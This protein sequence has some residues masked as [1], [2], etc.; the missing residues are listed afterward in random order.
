MGNQNQSIYNIF[1]FVTEEI[2][3]QET[4]DVLNNILTEYKQLPY[5]SYLIR[6]TSSK[7]QEHAPFKNILN[8]DYI[9]R[10]FS[11]VEDI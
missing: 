11:Y 8:N 3:I 7:P 10:C 6:N 9:I 2:P 1:F 4:R 5:F